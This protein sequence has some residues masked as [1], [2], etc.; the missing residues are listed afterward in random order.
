MTEPCTPCKHETD[1]W[2]LD[3][4]I[5]YAVK[6]STDA[7]CKT[8]PFKW[9]WM[10][11]VGLRSNP[12]DTKATLAE[13]RV[14]WGMLMY[15]FPAKDEPCPSMPDDPEPRWWPINAPKHIAPKMAN[16]TGTLI[17][18]IKQSAP[19]ELVVGLSCNLRGY[20]N[21]LKAK[22]P[23][24]DEQNGQSLVVWV[25]QQKW[26]CFGK[27]M[28]HGDV[29]DWMKMAHGKGLNWKLTKN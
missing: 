24:H 6:H 7:I 29:I 3:E 12:D 23:L 1:E 21:V 28:A 9:E 5:D 13:A 26:R 8:C 27:C 25:D 22:C 10:W 14:A 2:K 4:R 20:G 11:S 15:L 17:D 18:R 16:M 19:L